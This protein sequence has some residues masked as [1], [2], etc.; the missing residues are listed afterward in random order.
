MEPDLY[1]ALRTKDIDLVRDC[2]ADWGNKDRWI[3]WAGGNRYLSPLHVA[4]KGSSKDILLTLLHHPP[5]GI[6]INETTDK[7]SV[8]PLHVAAGNSS[9]EIVTLLLT[10]GA[11]ISARSGDGSTAFHIACSRGRHETCALLRRRGSVLEARDYEQRTPLMRAAA[12]GRSKVVRWLL[13]FGADPCA[14]D[15]YGNSVLA[16]SCRATSL[17]TARAL[18]EFGASVVVENSEGQSSAYQAAMSGQT[19]LLEMMLG[20]MARLGQRF[21]DGGGDILYDAVEHRLRKVVQLLSSRRGKELGVD[22]SR[23]NPS[24]SD[25]TPLH[26]AVFR[27]QH[28]IVNLLLECGACPNVGNEGGLGSLHFA[29]ALPDSQS[30][31]RSLLKAKADANAKDN[32]G[33]TPL[34]CELDT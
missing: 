20:S 15:S 11:D 12:C 26:A 5:I 16:H 33:C 34:Y 10:A 31:V 3:W 13:G 17:D 1:R 4:S 22:V 28:K 14:V 21:R 27:G 29:C 25:T 9:A 2:L 8:T 18:L 24:K 6:S 19:E 23:R 30:I 7:A 32:C